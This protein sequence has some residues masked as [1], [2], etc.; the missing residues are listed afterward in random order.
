MRI[1]V[2][3]LPLLALPMCAVLVT[4]DAWPRWVFMWLLA[5]TIYVACKWLTWWTASVARVP[6]WRHLAYLT[7]WPGLDAAAFLQGQSTRKP[8]PREW[9]FAL[10]KCT[11]GAALVWGVTPLLRDTPD[12]VRGW[13]GMFGI[14]FILHFGLFH[15][16]SLG[17]QSIGINAK[18]LMNWPALAT[19][20]SEFWSQRWNIAFR[21]L[22]HRY[23]FRPLTA[24]F[25]AR[26]A[27]IAVFVFSGIVHDFVISLPAGGGWGGPTLYFLVQ[28]AAVF[29]ERSS[30]GERFVLGQGVR[31]W[32]FAMVVLLAPVMLLFHPPFAREVVLPFLDWLTLGS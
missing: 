29:F 15:L 18:P 21:D 12:L 23:L 17:W 1:A 11:L 13:V 31:G 6:L 32:G 27:L 25:G 10:A 7:L 2:A 30:L 9:V 5:A 4:P 24:R 28:A 3:F 22:T 14:V 19:S 20:V 8:L 16:L 26:I